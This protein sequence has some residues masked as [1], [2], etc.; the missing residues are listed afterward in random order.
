M[1]EDRVSV[2]MVGVRGTENP[3][4]PTSVCSTTPLN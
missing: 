3:D 1:I 2:I 4:V